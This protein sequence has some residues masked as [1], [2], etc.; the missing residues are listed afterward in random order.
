MT[1]LRVLNVYLTE[2][3]MT[4][5]QEIMKM[6]GDTVSEYLEETDRTRKENDNLKRLLREIGFAV[7]AGLPESAQP[8]APAVP[9]T[10]ALVEE[11][12]QRSSSLGQ[13]AEPPLPAVKVELSEQQSARPGEE[14]LQ[15]QEPHTPG[16][17]AIY[18]G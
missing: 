17:F 3:L 2:R 9:V 6:V 14:E 11:Q 7:E 12:Q 16:F 5:A 1:R 15:A 18:L 13:D 4:A 10:V 8:A